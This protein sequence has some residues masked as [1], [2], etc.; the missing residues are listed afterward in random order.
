MAS[1]STSAN[2]VHGT[3]QRKKKRPRATTLRRRHLAS[4]SVGRPGEGVPDEIN[5]AFPLAPFVD[6]SSQPLHKKL[7]DRPSFCV[8]Q[9]STTPFAR[10]R[11]PQTAPKDLSNNP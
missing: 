5:A 3:E 9:F 10:P 11:A 8:E 2:L 7:W 4:E 6:T 1:F